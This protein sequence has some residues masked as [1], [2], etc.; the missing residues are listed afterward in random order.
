MALLPRPYPDEAIGSVIAR[1]VLHTGLP[2]KTLLQSLFG[3]T[4]SCSS[5]L[6]GTTFSKLSL[7]SG[8]DAEELMWSHTVFPYATAFMP[9][10]ARA[11]LVAKALDPKVNEDC[12]ASLTK[13]ASH[14]VPFRR[15]CSLCV[16]EELTKYGES[17]WHRQHLLPGTFVCRVHDVMLAT[18]DIPLRGRT[19]IRDVLLPHMVTGSAIQAEP[20]GPKLTRVAEY[21]F[22]ALNGQLAPEG[23]LI[24]YRARALE[25]GYKLVSGQVA[26]VTFSQK[27]RD[28][29][30]R[31]F[32]MDAGCAMAAKP[33]PS[34]MLRPATQVTFATPKHVLLQTFLELDGGAPD[35][36]A[37]AYEKPGK[38]TTDYKRLD[39]ELTLRM[40][41]VLKRA[42][43]RRM[44]VKELLTEAGSWGAFKHHRSEMPKAEELVMQ[45]RESDQAERQIGGREHW[46][47]R[48]PAKYSK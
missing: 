23:L 5:L 25:L 43:S 41:T 15:L 10:S 21:S 28:F 24:Q 34:L 14:G 32:L 11:E 12:L 39:S 40:K 18:T 6:M 19:H 46:R 22:Q 33:W 27:L 44:T 45:F 47:K 31:E 29:Y 8:T 17:Y 37:S 13:S 1:G 30:G 35:A 16:K 2:M 3:P 9:A 48:H 4:K 36:P 42:K 26:S 38:K 7:A 20:L